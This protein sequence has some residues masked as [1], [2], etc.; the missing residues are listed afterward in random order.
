M[1]FNQKERENLIVILIVILVVIYIFSKSSENFDTTIK[2]EDI[3]EAKKTIESESE[4]DSVN[5]VDKGETE[6]I[7][8][9]N[10]ELDKKAESER[11]LKLFKKMNDIFSTEEQTETN[12]EASI[13][14]N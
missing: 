12:E 10:N 8:I 7:T 4:S 14:P 5:K 6:N 2:C 11:L 1:V 9:D 3:Y 13:E